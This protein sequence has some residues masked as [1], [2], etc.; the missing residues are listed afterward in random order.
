MC[1][2]CVLLRTMKNHTLEHDRKNKMLC[3]GKG[4]NPFAY[5]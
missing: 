5:F 2:K 4:K 1:V 3:S